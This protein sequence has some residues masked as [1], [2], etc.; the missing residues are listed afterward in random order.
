MNGRYLKKRITIRIE[1]VQ[2]SRCR[3]DFKARAK[4]NQAAHIAAKAEGTKAAVKRWPAQPRAEGI[5]LAN[6][7][8][9]TITAIPYDILK[10]GV[11]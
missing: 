10:E 8:T 6:A 9:Q 7:E 11:L 5:I 4:A 2:P 1:H 3:E